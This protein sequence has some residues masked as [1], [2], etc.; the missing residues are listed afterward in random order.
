[1]ASAD[2]ER[3]VVVGPDSP[4]DMGRDVEFVLEDPPF[5]GPVA[6]VAAGVAALDDADPEGTVLVLACDLPQVA[7]VVELLSSADLGADGVVLVDDRDQPQYLAGRYRLAALRHRLGN[8][9]DADGNGGRPAASCHGCRG[10]PSAEVAWAACASWS[11]VAPVTSAPT[12]SPHSCE[13]A[14][15]R[16]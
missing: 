7:E 8:L 13:P 1:M 15:R 2:R 3:V 10:D 9:A 6:A 16:W 11:S 5:G 12:S 4:I 14:T